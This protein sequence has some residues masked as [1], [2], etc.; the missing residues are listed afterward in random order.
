MFVSSESVAAG[1]ETLKG[2][3]L[4]KESPCIRAGIPISNN[5]GRDLFG[6]LLPWAVPPSIGVHEYSLTI[7]P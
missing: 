2:F 7:A 6:N 3:R 4:K 5:G 1:F